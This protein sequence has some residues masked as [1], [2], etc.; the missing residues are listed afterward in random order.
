MVEI[1]N[2]KALAEEILNQAIADVREKKNGCL[3]R[4]D[5]ETA[6]A[7]FEAPYPSVLDDICA[8]AGVPADVT[9]RRYREGF[10]DRRRTA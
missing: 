2:Y 10:A 5:V 8:L 3:N 9:R 1:G 7:F 6:K 4:K